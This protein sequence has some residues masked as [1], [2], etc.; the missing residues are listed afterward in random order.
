MLFRS[1]NYLLDASRYDTEGY[2]DHSAARRDHLNGKLKFDAGAR[3]TLTVVVNTLDQPETQDPLGLTAAQVAQNP[4][5][6][7]TNALAFNTR[8]SVAQNQAGVVY[9]LELAPQNT[10]QARLYHG[11]RQ[12]TQ[13]LAIPLATQA[14]PTHSGGVVDLDRG[15]G[16]A[17]VRLTHTMSL[18]GGPLTLSAGIDYDHMSE[19]RTGFINNFG[20]TGAL[21]RDEDDTVTNTDVYTQ[22]EW[23]LAPRWIA[24]TGV[25]RSRV[26]FDSQDYFIAPGN[27]NDSGAIEFAKTTPVAGL[28]FRSEERRVGKECRL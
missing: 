1:V 3:G 2:R 27:P 21:K 13:F 14:A 8:K 4:R 12:V 7:G 11:D 28:V 10:L 18:A 23:Q 16:G 6:A 17:G 15:Y 20:V 9:D 22:A 25:R 26:R 24:S 19:H 5:Q